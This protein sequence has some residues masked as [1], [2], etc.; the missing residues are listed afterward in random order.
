MTVLEG[1]LRAEDPDYVFAEVESEALEGARQ[2]IDY[3]DAIAEP[4]SWATRIQL[5]SIAVAAGLTDQNR[6]VFLA[7]PD[8]FLQSPAGEDAD[9]AWIELPHVSYAI[10]RAWAG[11]VKAEQDRAIRTAAI[12]MIFKNS[13]IARDT[14]S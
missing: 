7:D 12:C 4:S 10:D 14:T 6:K 2:R 5:E 9:I 3:T 11:Y 13:R 1:K 8:G